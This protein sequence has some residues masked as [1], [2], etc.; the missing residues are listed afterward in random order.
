MVLEPGLGPLQVS[1]L[2]AP[3]QPGHTCPWDSKGVCIL[4]THYWLDLMVIISNSSGSPNE[5]VKAN[6]PEIIS[7]T[8][9][10]ISHVG[11][12]QEAQGCT[13]S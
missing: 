13:Q 4:I 10:G 11:L 2:G 8:L 3:S 5:A 9:A 1:M 6:Y 12:R 7:V